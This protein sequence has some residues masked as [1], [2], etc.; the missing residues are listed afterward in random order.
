MKNN[1]D[2]TSRLAKIHQTDSEK[3]QIR[4]YLARLK[5]QDDLQA[6]FFAYCTQWKLAPWMHTQ[7]ERNALGRFFSEKTLLDFSDTHDRVVAANEARNAESVRFLQ[8][9]HEQ[10]IDVAVLKGNL[11]AHTV[12]HDRGYKKM[13]DFDMLI[14]M[15][16]WEKIQGIYE[17]LNYIPLG[18]GW[19]G[20]KQKPAKFSHVGMSFISPNYA[21]IT[22]T[23]W[24]LKSPTSKY[25]VDIAEAW[26]TSLPYDFFGVPIRQLSPA[27]NLLH[28]ILHMGVYKCGIRDCMDVYNLLLAE[29]D[30][31]EDLLV[32]L[33]AR[34]NA[35]DKAYFTLKMTDQCSGEISPSLLEKLK[36][37][38]RNFLVRRTDARL[39]AAA[40]TGDMQLSY[41]DLFHDVE[42]NVIYFYLFPQ[43][44][45]KAYFYGRILKQALWPKMD[46]ALRL[47]DVS[48][49]PTLWNRLKARAKGA[50]FVFALHAEEI[51][52][53]IT[54]LLFLKF[55]IDLLLSLGNYLVK[56][57]SYFDYL[58]A[59]NIDPEDI[60]RVVKGIE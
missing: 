3:A 59:R 54:F 14:R 45:L 28:L 4:D 56:K 2:L 43:F 57:G 17:E 22:G 26:D 42:N 34:S 36:P 7:I 1:F 33:F 50:Y 51:G 9:F 37:A 11:L 16:D 13:N 19:S 10:S 27:Y 35:L 23:Q 21:V 12:Y 38:S 32:D 46:M 5:G 29:K 49:K 20:E 53:G 48:H 6:Q 31:D 58:K 55:F 47:S 15:D 18:F 25:T 44:H 8:K 39:K 24:G 60:K 40:E 52:W 30:L 41:N